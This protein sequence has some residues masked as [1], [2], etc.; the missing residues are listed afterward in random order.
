M[1]QNETR[2]DPE[3][4]ADEN[5]DPTNVELQFMGRV[6][7]RAELAARVE[8]ESSAAGAYKKRG[9]DEHDVALKGTMDASDPPSTNMGDA[10]E[11]MT[12]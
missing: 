6:N 9:M 11:E 8:A 4:A 2:P 1:T 7:A 12:S 3:T 10:D 5:Q